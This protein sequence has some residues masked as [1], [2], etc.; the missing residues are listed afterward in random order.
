MYMYINCHQSSNY[1]SAFFLY[2]N[3]HVHKCTL[4]R[5]TEI[6]FFTESGT[7]KVHAH[8]QYVYTYMY[9]I[10]VFLKLHVYL[11]FIA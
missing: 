9:Y 8:V 2:I 1:Y 3:V 4:N 10:E 7:I 11:V 6:D 5:N